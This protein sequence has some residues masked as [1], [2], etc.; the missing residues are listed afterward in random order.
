[1][2]LKLSDARVYEPQIRARLARAGS[3]PELAG[4]P[5]QRGFAPQHPQSHGFFFFFFFTLVTGLRR[6]LSLKLSD[7]HSH[8]ECEPSPATQLGPD[9]AARTQK[10]AFS[11]SFIFRSPDLLN[12]GPNR[13]RTP[14]LGPYS[15]TMPRALWL[16][17]GGGLFLLSEVNSVLNRT[18]PCRKSDGTHRKESPHGF[19]P[20]NPCFL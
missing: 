14:L 6:S 18:R 12:S 7:S 16:S 20:V 17:W 9:P 1:M 4:N 13:N 10:G 2:H 19:G 8:A 11:R 5:R 3:L 15:R